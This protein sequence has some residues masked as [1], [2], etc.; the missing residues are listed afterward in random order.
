MTTFRQAA[1]GL[2]PG[3]P[4][5]VYPAVG[6]T[7]LGATSG[8]RR[9]CRATTDTARTARSLPLMFRSGVNKVASTVDSMEQSV[10]KTVCGIFDIF[11]V[12]DCFKREV[13]NMASLAC[14][15]QSPYSDREFNRFMMRPRPEGTGETRNP[16]RRNR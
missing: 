4:T 15:V 5:A 13:C 2:T 14:I 7:F 16:L 3:K 10:H 9:Q 8:N 12:S 11:F 6:A 1:E